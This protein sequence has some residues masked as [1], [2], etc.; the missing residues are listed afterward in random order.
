MGG[1]KRAGG[2]QKKKKISSFINMAAMVIVYKI[3]GLGRDPLS[4]TLN[5][6]LF[7]GGQQLCGFVS[8]LAAF[9]VITFCFLKNW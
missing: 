6:A 2:G 3:R 8:S 9:L 1:A 5:R 4:G 7:W